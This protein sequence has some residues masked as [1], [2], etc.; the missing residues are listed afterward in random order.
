MTNPNLRIVSFNKSNAHSPTKTAVTEDRRTAQ[1]VAAANVM[2]DTTTKA[3]SAFATVE[4][5]KWKD[6]VMTFSKSCV[7]ASSQ[8]FHF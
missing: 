2:R 8:Q 1:P 6:A 7:N 5:T 4:V 3:T